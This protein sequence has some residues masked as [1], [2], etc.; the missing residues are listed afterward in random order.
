MS[1]KQTNIP[2]KSP[3]DIARETFRRLAIERVAPTPQAYRK[4]YVEISGVADEELEKRAAQDL[5]E[6]KE[7]TP[8][9]AR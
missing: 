6:A 3:T 1:T 2:T 4:L 7:V 5:I 8:S 9:S